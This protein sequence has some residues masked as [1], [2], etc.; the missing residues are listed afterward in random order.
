MHEQAVQLK[1][2]IDATANHSSFTQ[3]CGSRVAKVGQKRHR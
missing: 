2:G 3:H 1:K